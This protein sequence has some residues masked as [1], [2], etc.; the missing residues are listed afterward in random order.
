M[1]EI[2]ES[3]HLAQQWNRLIQGRRIA[4]AETE[5]TAHSFAFY[6]GTPGEYRERMERKTAGPACGIGSMVEAEIGRYRFLVGDGAN[7]RYYAPEEKLPERYQTRLTFDDGSSLICTI[8]MYGSMFLIQPETF[9]N[10]YYRVA[11]EKPMPCTEDFDYTWFRSLQEEETVGSSMSVKAF[12]A[13]QQRIPGLGNGVLQDILLEAGMHPKRKLGT[14]RETDWQI[15]YHAVLKVLGEMIA[16][17]GRNT[18]KDM[19]G[20]PGG[21]R[22]KLSKKTYGGPCPYCGQA[23]QKIAYLGG[24]VYFCP[25]CQQ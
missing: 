3:L 5:H 4:E 1:I 23:I 24:T 6:S 17:G 16:G 15:L 2:P 22:T 11:K 19:L 8:A 12:L 25:Q 14:L 9:D 10:P 21:Y 18:E 20:E 13:T 7:M